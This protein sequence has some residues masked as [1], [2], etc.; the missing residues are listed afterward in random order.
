VL[1]AAFLGEES[2]R[3]GCRFGEAEEGAVFYLSVF[4]PAGEIVGDEEE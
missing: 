4:D 2:G 3:K 1:L